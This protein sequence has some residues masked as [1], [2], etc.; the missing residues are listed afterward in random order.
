[1]FSTFFQAVIDDLAHLSGDVS[2]IAANVSAL[3]LRE[4]GMSYII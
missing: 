4:K 2:K 1:M 3:Q